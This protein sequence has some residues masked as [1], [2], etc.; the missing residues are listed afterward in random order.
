M[1]TAIEQRD[2]LSCCDGALLEMIMGIEENLTL[3]QRAGERQQPIADRAQGA[4]MA[5]AA[6]AQGGIALSAYRIMLG[7]DARPVIEGLLQSGIAG[8]PPG[9]EAD[10]A[11]AP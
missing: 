6:L 9:H 5:V 3:K 1:V 10:L 11:A 4:G 8:K 7:G 2:D